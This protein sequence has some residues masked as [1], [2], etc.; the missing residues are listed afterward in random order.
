[1]LK[2]LQY[3]LGFY[4]KRIIALHKPQIVGITGSVGKTSAKE[5]IGK[6]LSAQFNVRETY[7]NYN[8][9]IGLPLTI[10]GEASAGR[11]IS[12][13]LKIFKK[14]RTL[15]KKK[16]I[17]YPDILILEMGIDHPGDM[18]Y[19]TSIAK[20]SRAVITKLGQAHLEFFKSIEDL[21]A[22]KLRLA[23]SLYEEG[24]IIYNA[25]D[26]RLVKAVEKINT[27]AIGFGF[28]EKAQIQAEHL[29]FS[30]DQSGVCGQSFKLV[31]NG[32]SIPVFLSGV[33]GRPAVYAALAAAA[34]A[35][36]FNMNGLEVAEAIRTVK[37]PAGRMQLIEGIEHTLIVDDTYNSSPDSVFEG[38]HALEQIP[39]EKR[40]RLWA[41][42]G[43]MKELGALSKR[44]HEEVALAA[45]KISDFVIAVGEEAKMISE[46]LSN[47]SVHSMW[48]TNCEEAAD[49]IEAEIM[50]D[51]LLYIKGSQAA[52][53]EK[54]VKR[55]MANPQ[56]AH[57]LLVRQEKE[58]K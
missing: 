42:L 37:Q 2:I 28:S 32:S 52:R 15:S 36:S 25:D 35:S 5:A 4:A 41:V 39:K 46:T 19:L 11:S 49:Y 50:A 57:E 16:D 30:I 21:H 31:Y 14:A 47:S 54:I 45:E 56:K 10:I 33:L 58:W 12:G 51:D 53:M 40:K 17:S 13:W 6:I 23:H 38:L 34:T 8:N 22:E 20:P 9:E 44:S 29:S 24:W 48:F 26:E 7:K 18:N 43:S 3:I 1:M 27:Q 55:L